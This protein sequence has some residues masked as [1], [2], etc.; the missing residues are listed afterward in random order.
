VKRSRFFVRGAVQGVGFRPHV[1][2]LATEKGLAGFVM[3]SPRGVTIEVEGPHDTVDEFAR[4]LVDELPPNADILELDRD[5]VEPQGAGSF[6]IRASEEGGERTAVLLADLATCPECLRELLDTG[7]RRHLYPFT[8]CTHCGPRYTIIE[9][10]PY[11]RPNTTMR[12]FEMCDACRME[13]DSPLDRRFHAQP[14][15]CPECG[16]QLELWRPSG[17]ILASRHDALLRAA[18]QIGEGEI[19]AVK[20]I[21]GFHLIVDATNPRAVTRLRERK[22]RP[23]KPFAVMFPT[24]EAIHDACELSPK[25]ETLLTSPRAPIVLLRRASEPRDPGIVRQVAPGNPMIG[26]MLPYSPIHHLLLRETGRPVVATSGNLSEEPIC[27]DER[28]ALERL[29]G[30]ADLFLVHDRPIAR[31][32]DDSVVRVVLER[33]LPLRRA[34]G[35]APMPVR[36]DEPLDGVL[37]VGAHLKNTVAL[38]LARDVFVSPHIG[39][40]EGKPSVEAF[41]RNVDC[42]RTIYEIDRPALARDLHPDYVSTRFADEAAAYGHGRDPVG[43]QHHFAHVVSCMADNG[44]SGSVLGVSWDGTGYGLDGTV[45]GGEFLDAT[46][47]EFT[48]LAHL[49]PFRLPGGDAAVKEPRRSAVGLLF[50]VLGPDVLDRE[51]LAPV[52]A[53][54]PP[55]RRVLRR[56]L[57]RGVNAPRT[58]SMGRL[59]D[60]VASI[61]GL[62]Q[63]SHFE[64]QAAMA[65]E[66]AVDVT[67]DDPP[68]PMPLA[69]G[70]IDFEP[71]LRDLLADVG[72]GLPIGRISARFHEA[73][74]GAIV[75]VARVAGRQRVVLTGGCFQN[76]VLLERAVS[77][78]RE[79]GFEPIW[80]RQVPPN[81]G[82]ISLGQA[83]AVGSR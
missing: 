36:C 55:E 13:Y 46:R 54:E 11:D 71:M 66:F 75:A 29:H 30:I 74:A 33:E 23:A 18:V 64:G 20:G 15:A 35:Y 48:R 10:L 8:N 53:F 45:W 6:E 78:L 76:A 2:R 43:V 28:E 77:R 4:R 52:L 70:E 9:S 62:R 37:A 60:A 73:L 38:G 1:Y 69:E 12:R 31:P 67:A 41:E 50:A 49:R 44:I 56:M 40:L 42:L 51:D 24:V 68:Y 21:G 7:D 16:P 17:E 81:D 5:D 61:A 80:H 34:R 79:R 57:A 39:D 22:R 82:G 63:T 65:L 32:V 47:R 19:V 26:S 83:V 25:E 59:F 58:S 3:N 27:F 72:A 14:N